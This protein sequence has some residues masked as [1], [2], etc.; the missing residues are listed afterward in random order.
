MADLADSPASA[1]DLYA[2]RFYA[3]RLRAGQTLAL[4]ARSPA[5]VFH[6]IE[7][8]VDVAGDPNRATIAPCVCGL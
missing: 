3:L 4:P 7:G 6:L 8:G 2:S 5:S 1:R